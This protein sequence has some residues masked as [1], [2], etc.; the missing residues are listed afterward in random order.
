[1]VL[2]DAHCALLRAYEGRG[3]EGDKPAPLAASLY[4]PDSQTPSPWPER[5]AHAIL[6]APDGV[7]DDDARVRG[8]QWG[9]CS[10]GHSDLSCLVCGLL[11]AELCWGMLQ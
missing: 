6:A 3:L 11:S 9:V 8:P 7:V 2:R 1:M 4:H 10:Q 5:A